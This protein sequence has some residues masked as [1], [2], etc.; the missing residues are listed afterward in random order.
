MAEDDSEPL[1]VQARPSFTRDLQSRGLAKHEHRELLDFYDALTRGML[2][3]HYQEHRLVETLAGYWECHL[4]AHW[5][6]IYK[7]FS[8]RVVLHRTGTHQ[9]LFKRTH[10]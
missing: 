3:P 10:T 7:R 6:V 2:P 1:I 9:Q 4:A 8:D 5:L